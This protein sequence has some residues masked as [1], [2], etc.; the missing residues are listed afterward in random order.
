MWRIL[1]I[2]FTGIIFSF[3]YFPFEFSFFPGYN[4]KMLLAVVGGLIAV[5]KLVETKEFRVPR[6]VLLIVVFAILV[7]I[8]GFI[9]IIY[10]STTD[11]V[12]STYV[13]SMLVWLSAAYAIC[14]IIKQVHSR[15]DVEIIIQYIISVS[16]A[17]CVLAQFIDVMPN[18]KTY[19]DMYIE[20]GQV[21]LNEVDRL[22]GIGANL[23]VAGTRFAVALIVL[24]YMLYVNKKLHGKYLWY[25]ICAYILIAVLGSMI[26]RTT[27]VGIVISILFLL[28]ANLFS[29]KITKRGTKVIGVV[30]LLMAISVPASIYLYNVNPNFHKLSRFAFEGFFNLAETG[31]WTIASSERLMT[32]YIFPDNFK[33]WIIGD[34][35]FNNPVNV[36]PYYVGEITGGYY[37]GTD[38]GYLRFIFY[39]GLIG[40]FTFMLFFIKVS[41]Y[42][43]RGLP[44]YKWMFIMLLLANFVIWFK[45]STDIFLAFALF[46]CA[47]NMQDNPQQLETES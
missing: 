4:T 21:F 1:S 12:Y 27:Y 30:L 10:N 14:C 15:L 34:G 33:T 43:V 28:C 45:V 23:D 18:L 7:S 35:Y 16:L 13:V 22:Y 41:Q 47:T 6:N 36:D 46:L 38:V 17:Q 24:V 19:V 39:F 44:K 40:L 11:Y 26:A 37:K 29:F 8:V 42:C 2:I 25:Y 9:S 31:E 20:Q 5:F 32:M 3:Y